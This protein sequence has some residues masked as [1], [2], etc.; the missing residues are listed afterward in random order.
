MANRILETVKGYENAVRELKCFATSWGEING[1]P[2]TIKPLEACLNINTAESGADE[3][4]QI[5]T[6]W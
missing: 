6:C 2:M 4:Y 5:E 1:R 3:I